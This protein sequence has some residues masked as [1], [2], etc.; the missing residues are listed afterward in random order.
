MEETLCR[1]MLVL[2]NIMVHGRDT[3]LWNACFSL[4]ANFKS[5]SRR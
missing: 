3:V 1:E 4:E 5:F 2:S